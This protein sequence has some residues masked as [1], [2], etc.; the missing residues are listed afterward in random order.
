MA[1][2]GKNR[3]EV[4]GHLGNKPEL[5]FTTNGTPVSN[6]RVCVNEEWPD[7]NTG[8]TMKHE[9]WFNVVCWKGLGKA[10]AENLDK[11]RQVFVEGRIRTRYYNRQMQDINGHDV[12][13]SWPVQEIIASSVLFLGKRPNTQPQPSR[14][15]QQRQGYQRPNHRASR[16]H[17]R[18]QQQRRQP[19][20]Q[21]DYYP[22]DYSGAYSGGDGVYHDDQRYNV[23]VNDVI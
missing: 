16:A 23:S 17:P 14:N 1:S 7:K 10:V 6:F 15:N 9:E 2:N 5:R 12:V 8:Q 22:E 20:P 21:E 18:P 3:M 13:V 19:P 11:G 4:I